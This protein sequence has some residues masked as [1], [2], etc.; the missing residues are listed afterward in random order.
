MRINDPEVLAE[1]T[2]A[3]AAYEA[4]LMANDVEGLDALFWNSDRTIRYGPGENLYGFAEIAAFRLARPGGSPQRVLRRT[5]ITTF[6]RDYATANTEFLREGSARIGRQSQTWLRT[7]QGWRIVAAHVS[8]MAPPALS[9]AIP[10]LHGRPVDA[11]R[12]RPLPAGLR[13]PVR[14]FALGGG[15]GLGAW[16]RSPTPRR[17]TRAFLAVIDDAD[18]A[19]RLALVRAHPQLADKAAIAEGLTDSSAAEQASAGLDRLTPRGI[20]G[21]PPSEPVLSRA[22]RLSVHHLRAAA[23]QGRHPGGHAPAADR[24]AAESELAEALAQIGLIAKLRLRR[25]HLGGPVVGI[26]VAG[27][28]VHAAE[29][30]RNRHGPSSRPCGDAEPGRGRLYGL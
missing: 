25:G 7:P 30:R 10:D 14:I 9:A 6:D 11:A 12:P 18:P 16:G 20:P 26:E 28:Y 4:A 19:E 1:V 27:S 3:F 24:R 17:C 2:A 8:L 21:L 29:A 23:R 15:A 22:V 13:P 5:V